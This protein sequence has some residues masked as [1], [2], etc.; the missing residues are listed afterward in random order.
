MH[1]YS[2][3]GILVTRGLVAIAASAWYHERGP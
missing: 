1:C 2:K 3:P